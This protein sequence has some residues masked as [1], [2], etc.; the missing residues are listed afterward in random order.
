MIVV[1]MYINYIEIIRVR[2]D[3]FCFSDGERGF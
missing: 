1:N 3:Y 2:T